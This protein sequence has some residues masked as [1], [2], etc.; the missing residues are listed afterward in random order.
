MPSVA[1]R[2]Q[3]TNSLMY[4]IF[5]RGSAKNDIFHKG[6]DY[7]RFIGILSRYARDHELHVYHWALMPSH[8]HLLVELSCPER[9]SSIM[10]GIA[11]SYV[12]YHHRV[13]ESVGH[14]WQGRFKSQPIE[15][16]T[17]LLSCGRY[18]ERNPVKA[19]IVSFAEDY[20][21]SSAAYYVFGRPDELTE[22]DPL[23]RSFGEQSHRRREGYTEFI[24]DF[25]RE[26]ELLFENL[27]SPRGSEEFLHRLIRKRGLYLPRRTGRP[28]S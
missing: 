10:A 18:I 7:Q 24:R 26:E 19:R 22:E 15:K 13:H 6:E 5:N 1:R 28:R 8:C 12:H 17:Y 27:E 21:Y 11:R 4:H 20:L 14:L 25:S 16:E 2:H 23:F 9:L 3:L